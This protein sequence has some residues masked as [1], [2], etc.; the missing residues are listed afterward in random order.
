MEAAELFA[1]SAQRR[2]RRSTLIGEPT[3]IAEID[4]S[5]SEPI[6]RRRS[7]PPIDPQ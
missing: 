4:A 7:S 1:A 6:R 3:I 2:R 5:A